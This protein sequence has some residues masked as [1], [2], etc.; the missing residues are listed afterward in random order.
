MTTIEDMVLS[1]ASFPS[2][3]LYSW[4][5]TLNPYNSS[6][7]PPTSNGE[8]KQEAMPAL[9]EP[10]HLQG[11]TNEIPTLS[12]S[13]LTT[14]EIKSVVDA[15]SPA[16]ANESTEFH[17][18]E[19]EIRGLIDP[20]G[21]HPPQS[22]ATSELVIDMINK[23]AEDVN[24]LK[25]GWAKEKEKFERNAQ[26]HKTNYHE[27]EGEHNILSREE[28]REKEESLQLETQNNYLKIQTEEKIQIKVDAEQRADNAEQLANTKMQKRIDEVKAGL[29]QKKKAEVDK[30]KQERDMIILTKRTIE[31]ELT[32]ARREV[33]I[34]REQQTTAAE[35][36]TADLNDHKECLR[37]RD[38]DLTTSEKLTK[39]AERN[40]E[41]LRNEK[42]T[43]HSNEVANLKKQLRVSKDLTKSLEPWKTKAEN[44][45]RICQRLRDKLT[46]TV[47][48]IRD[49]KDHIINRLELDISGLR[50]DMATDAV[51]INRKNSEIAK[52]NSGKGLLKVKSELEQ[53]KKLLK[54]AELEI[55]NLRRDLITGEAKSK[56]DAANAMMET[57]SQHEDRR[58]AVDN[59]IQQAETAAAGKAAEKDQECEQRISIA[60][61]E[62][63]KNAAVEAEKEKQQ[64]AVGMRAAFDDA[65]KNAAV[66]V[67]NKE[68]HYAAIMEAAV[69]HARKTVNEMESKAAA[70][71]E[72]QAA[73]E[74]EMDITPDPD[75]DAELMEDVDDALRRER[76]NE[77]AEAVKKALENAKQQH[78]QEKADAVQKAVGMV[79]KEAEQEHQK[80]M[81]QAVQYAVQEAKIKHEKEKND[82]IA[83]KKVAEAPQRAQEAP[84]QG[85]QA[86][87]SDVA[88][89]QT[90]SNPID[91]TLAATEADEASQLLEEVVKCGMAMGTVEYTVLRRLMDIRSALHNLKVMLQKPDAPT[92]TSHY[93][94]LLLRVF[95]IEEYVLRRLE[96]ETP[97]E[98]L[99]RQA[100]LANER[101]KSVKEILQ[102][103]DFQKDAILQALI[104]PKREVAQARGL[105]RPAQS[106]KPMVDNSQPFAD[107]P[108]TPSATPNNRPSFADQMKA[109]NY[110]PRDF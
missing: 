38:L 25:R 27:L 72:K 37:K 108:P 31:T 106:K 95:K 68:Q 50:R 110:Y 87:S 13:P 44:Y 59:A 7:L 46:A 53:A 43:K 99:V 90:G 67:A 58:I 91:L 75:L 22:K 79:I 65:M 56:Q 107:Y 16:V 88:D 74:T 89:S 49:H 5:S 64:Y 24:G 100:R 104:G 4:S 28:K 45:E 57:K 83:A 73:R 48:D 10:N 51:T 70:E 41:A 29:E 18:F 6:L 9:Y 12:F 47:E 15:T 76:Q 94:D 42:C 21:I 33:S 55:K 3:L 35:K 69:E 96:S 60:V 81:A 11:G 77:I 92:E 17:V 71:A 82:L 86:K 36:N 93:K 78:Q 101:L 85:T 8:S 105:K 34:L 98:L 39:L 63:M 109:L 2:K 52:L 84:E 102:S 40:L 97:H 19:N 23:H 66:E 80:K 54:V 1:M 20:K 32:K 62:A 103:S 26:E 61:K 14:I 30:L